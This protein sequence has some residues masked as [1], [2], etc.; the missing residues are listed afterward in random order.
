MRPVSAA[1]PVLSLPAA[2]VVFKPTMDDRY[3]AQGVG[4][5]AGRVLRSIQINTAEQI[6]EL[7]GDDRGFLIPPASVNHLA[8]QLRVVARKPDV[9]RERARQARAY[10]AAH[11]TWAK[12]G[13]TLQRVLTAARDV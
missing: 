1:A 13:D 9:A 7:V 2:V 4:S 8:Q 12:M 3:D 10:V 6:P 11:R 5:H